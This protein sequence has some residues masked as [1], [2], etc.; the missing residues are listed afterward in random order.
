MAMTHWLD[1]LGSLNPQFL[2]ECRG[3]LKSRNVLAAVGLSLIFQFLLYIANSDAAI[4]V[5]IQQQA[6]CR[7]L[8]WTIPYALF[9][10]GGYYLVD[11]LAKEEKTGTLNFIR[12]SPR[13]AFEILL[14]KLL[15]VPLLPLILIATA[16]PLHIVSGLLGGFSA[17][18]LLSYYLLVIFG[19]AFVF[20]LALLFGLVGG[21]SPFGKQQSLNSIGFAALALFILAPMFILANSQLSWWSFAEASPL[22]DDLR[23]S[24]NPSDPGGMGTATEWLYLPVAA[25]VAIA[26]LFT[27]GN[28]AIASLLIWQVVLRQFR[29]PRSTLL[30]KRLSYVVV[31]YLNVLVWGFFQSSALSENARTNGALFLAALNVVIFGVLIFALAPARQTL[32]DWLRY[33]RHSLADWI[34]NDSSPSLGAIAVNLAIAAGLIVP[35]LFTLAWTT[36]IQAVPLL[37]SILS[38]ATSILI[39]ASLVQI[40]FSTKLRSP[41]IWALGTVAIIAFVPPTILGLL[42]NE[43]MTR[44][45]L[46]IAVWTLCGL[47][48]W[49]TSELGSASVGIVIGWVMQMVILLLLLSQLARNLKQLSAHR[50]ADL[51]A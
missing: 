20:S 24:G 18:W 34:W 27:L 22:F 46:M 28:L 29:V 39:Y 19:A 16:V 37:L 2:R 8:T 47:P 17:L 38:M 33:R 3:R 51:R 11:D 44:S 25:N 40:I 35:W 30:S 14:G 10:L 31:A 42:T 6:I 9:V 50:V 5:E 48:F 45:P 41:Q 23:M 21:N 1:Q 43:S 4:P 7:T 32:L 49:Q 26:H 15:G 36:E 13:P 12:L